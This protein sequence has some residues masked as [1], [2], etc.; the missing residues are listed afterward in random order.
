MELLDVVIDNKKKTDIE[1]IL[2]CND[3]NTEKIKFSDKVII[4]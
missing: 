1:E 2:K 4:L 3:I